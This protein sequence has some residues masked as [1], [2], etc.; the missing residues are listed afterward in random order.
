MGSESY[1]LQDAEVFE[2]HQL[3]SVPVDR[4]FVQKAQR[5]L[6]RDIPLQQITLTQM[7]GIS[8]ESNRQNAGDASVEEAV[9]PIGEHHHPSG[10]ETCQSEDEIAAKENKEEYGTEQ[11]Q[12]E[13]EQEEEDTEQSEYVQEREYHDV[14]SRVHRIGTTESDD[15]PND[16]SF[17]LWDVIA[18]MTQDAEATTKNDHGLQQ[19]RSI[20]KS[21]W[22]DLFTSE[23]DINDDSFKDLWNLF[24]D[25][26]D[27]DD[28][29]QEGKKASTTSCDRKEELGS[30]LLLS[31]GAQAV[32]ENIISN[33][34]SKRDMLDK[35]CPNW[36][37]NIM[38]ALRQDDDDDIEPAIENVKK[39]RDR[40]LKLRETFLL[41]WE[42]QNTALEVFETALEAS[43]RRRKTKI[44]PE[45]MTN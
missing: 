9:V 43:A 45:E 22:D 42:G 36:Q 23:E 40:M 4:A 16:V 20:L 14:I 7:I 12:Q 6:F 13:E 32:A 39:C 33:F 30:T 5:R 21:K 38:F 2:K 17:S 26:D 28:D 41:A 1:F 34:D 24:D 18:P 15:F 3:E 31:P 10:I 25:D 8:K 19:E 29:D 35:S 44:L 37:E 11:K 27:D